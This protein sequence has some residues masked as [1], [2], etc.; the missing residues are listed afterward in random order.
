MD[1]LE[2]VF[3]E[4]FMETFYY[5]HHHT[6]TN[7]C[8]LLLNRVETI[9]KTGDIEKI[10]ILLEEIK[11]AANAHF[12]YEF[13]WESLAPISEGG[14]VVPDSD[15]KLG[16][17][18]DKAFGSFDT[19]IFRFISKLPDIKEKSWVWLA[20]NKNTDGIEFVI[21][22][23]NGSLQTDFTEYVPLFGIDHTMK[24]YYIELQE[25]DPKNK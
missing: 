25:G 23:D 6:Y 17:A 24:S 8:N 2:P 20:Y 3:T 16:M 14:G 4:F 1:G 11:H 18:I 9:E 22:H 7:Y 12:N 19:F 10:R 21:T 5:V 13:F 15:S